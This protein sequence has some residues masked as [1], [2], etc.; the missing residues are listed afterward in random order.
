EVTYASLAP[1]DP[2][3]LPLDWDVTDEVETELRYAGYIAQHDR[4]LRR[5]VETWDGQAIPADLAFET[6]R[7][8]SNEA[9]E[10]LRRHHPRTIAQARRIPGVTPAAVSLLL[11]HLHRVGATSES[12]LSSP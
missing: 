10:K 2:G 11:V 5:E 3:R 6:I 1:E 4:R 7:G 12:A 9:V 8:L